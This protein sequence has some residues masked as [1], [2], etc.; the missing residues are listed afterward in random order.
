MLWAWPKQNGGDLY[1]MFA[2]CSFGCKS[3]HR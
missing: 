2:T 1:S 3:P